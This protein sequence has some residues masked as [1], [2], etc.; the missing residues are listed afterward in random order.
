MKTNNFKK[1]MLAVL[2]VA[3]MLA[4]VF[5]ISSCTKEHTHE[6]T[7]TELKAATCTEEGLAH[8]VCACGYEEDAPIP[9]L[10]HTL[11]HHDRKFAT[12]TEAGYL[13][14]D[15]CTVCG[16][17]DFFE[18]AQFPHVP[19]NPKIENEDSYTCTEDGS[20][21]EVIYCK[22]CENEISRVNKPIQTAGHVY[23]T[24]EAKAATC[25]VGW[26]EHE[27]CEVCHDKKGYVEIAPVYDHLMSEY[28]IE[29][30]GTRVNPTCTEDGYYHEAVAC[31]HDCGFYYEETF[32]VKTLE[33]LG[34]D[35]VDHAA[36]D[37]DCVNAGWEA[38]KTCTRCDYNDKVTIPAL[39]H[40]ELEAVEENRVEPTC[41]KDGK[42]DSVVYCEVCGA[43]VSRKEIKIDALGHD[44]ESHEAQAVS[45]TEIGWNAYETCKVCDYTTYKEIPA[46]GHKRVE[47]EIENFVEPTCTEDGS[48]DR[49]FVCETCGV[50]LERESWVVPAVAHNT[51]GYAEAKA[52]T[53]TEDGHEGYVCC[54]KCGYT[55]AEI[56]VLPATGHKL[57]QHDAKAP[58]CTEPGHNAYEDCSA[59]D[60]TT[61][62]E[63]GAKGHN[64]VTLYAVANSCETDGLTA[65][66]YCTGCDALTVEQQVI[67]ATGHNRDENGLCHNCGNKMSLGLS[68][69]QTEGGLVF[70]GVGSCTDKDIVIPDEI[71]GKKVIA[72]ADKAF[73]R[74]NVESVVIPATVKVI[75][76]E[77]FFSCSSLKTVVIGEGI[78]SIG[79]YAFFGCSRLTTV[80]ISG[81]VKS[82]GAYAFDLCNKLTTVYYDGTAAEWAAI[83][84]G[85]NNDALIGA[86]RYY[87]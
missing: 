43:E 28:P 40:T 42:Y 50:E 76:D 71:D 54:S 66:Q 34:H 46:T 78:E 79:E 39:G 18:V 5:T 4:T 21:D 26:Y 64:V 35:H 36:Q 68:Y 3:L 65:G 73:K 49:V 22:E 83:S 8:N 13:P 38:Y 16:W 63:I 52:P 75:G 56:V 11:I 32:A 58:T 72:V 82:I 62:V 74:S 77:A 59:C 61:F 37:P 67:P 24:V 19:G 48:Y 84:I 70:T 23:K 30:K 12:C 6:F 17:N 57:T 15:E 10:G 87:I 55:D 44:T 25:T 80:T 14:Y 45:C 1:I 20:Y 85:R 51:L 33:A 81:D 53:C 27:E 47:A 9:A 41:T 31:R 60:Y 69:E 2:V 86:T 7:S 29:L